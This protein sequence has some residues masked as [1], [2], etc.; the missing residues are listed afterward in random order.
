MIGSNLALPQG[1]LCDLTIIVTAF[2]AEDTLD[3][4]LLSCLP[5]LADGA[6]LILVNDASSDA[7]GIVQAEF[8]AAH[9]AVTAIDLPQNIGPGAA[10]NHAVDKVRTGLIGFMDGDDWVSPSYYQVLGAAMQA[11][12]VDFV[13]CHHIKATGTERE[14]VRAPYPRPGVPF[15]PDTAI[16]PGDTATLVD[17]PFS[18]MGLSRTKLWH[19]GGLRFSETRSAEDRLTTWEMHLLEGSAMVVEE[20]GYLYR[21]GIATSLTSVGDVRQLDFLIVLV[22]VIAMLRERGRTEFLPKAL[23]QLLALI[24]MHHDRRARLEPNVLAEFLSRSRAI[25]ADLPQAELAAAFGGIDPQR[26]ALIEG[27]MA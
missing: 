16:L 19:E 23:R 21:R 13:R 18:P 10:R 22:D 27:L 26:R 7:T 5:A 2:Q 12:E 25:L 14:L 24:A 11:H 15:P 17:Y 6:A 9:P 8:A 1:V 20:F 3:V 4:A